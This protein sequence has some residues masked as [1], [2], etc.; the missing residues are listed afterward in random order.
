MIDAI[1][2]LVN[3]MWGVIYYTPDFIDRIIAYCIE[4]YLYLQ[5]KSY[6]WSVKFFWGIAS[7]VISDFGI[8]GI[9]T[10]AISSLSPVTAGFLSRFGFFDGIP[11]ILNAGVTRF[12]MDLMRFK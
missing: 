5:I 9:V 12:V 3:E 8:N 7:V 6:L 1:T 2:G 10:S 11:L 4:M